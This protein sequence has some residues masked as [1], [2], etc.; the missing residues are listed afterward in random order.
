MKRGRENKEKT[1]TKQKEKIS[2]GRNEERNEGA[3]ERISVMVVS[4][5]LSILIGMLLVLAL[6]S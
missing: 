6:F 5:N 4:K 2:D 1:K 3:R